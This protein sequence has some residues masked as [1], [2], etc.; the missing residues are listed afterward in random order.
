[1]S[2]HGRL[3]LQIVCVPLSA[4]V[5]VTGPPSR[6]HCTADPVTPPSVPVSLATM[7]FLPLQAIATS[8]WMSV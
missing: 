8:S 7:R 2:Y 3:D 4:S 6:V 1:V 5:L